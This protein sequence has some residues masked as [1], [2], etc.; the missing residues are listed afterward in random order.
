MRQGSAVPVSAVV[1]EGVG[2]PWRV[3]MTSAA[4]GMSWQEVV[5]Q[6]GATAAMQGDGGGAAY[7]GGSPHDGMPACS[8]TSHV[9]S[10]CAMAGSAINGGDGGDMQEQGAAAGEAVDGASSGQPPLRAALSPMEPISH[11]L[12]FE[13]ADRKSVV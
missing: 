6:R 13:R 11:D 12:G 4:P 10:A 9:P 3:D 5:L 8:V 1:R 7:A 2:V